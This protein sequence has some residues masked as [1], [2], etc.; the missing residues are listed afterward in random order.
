MEV[1]NI[2]EEKTEKKLFSSEDFKIEV[3]NL[4]KYFG[5]GQLKKLFSN[6]MKLDFH[7][8]KP[9]GPKTNY[10]YICF[11]N[12]EDKQKALMVIEGFEF[13]GNKLR[14]K[15]IKGVT[16][17]YRKK[18]Q[19]SKET[20][21]DTRPVAEQLQ[22][23]VCPLAGLPYEQQLGRKASEVG[24]LVRR[25]GSE[26]SRVHPCLKQWVGQQTRDQDTL[27]PVSSVLRSPLLQGYRNKCEFSVGRGSDGQVCVG[28][29]LASYKAGSVEIVSLAGLETPTTTLPHISAQMLAAV[30][31]FEQLVRASSLPPY[32][33]LDRSGNWRSLMLRSSRTGQLMAVICLD[34]GGVA[35]AQLSKVREDL[36]T[37]HRDVDKEEAGRVSSLYLHLSPARKEPGHVEPAPELL[38]GEAAIQETLLGR[39]FNISPQA[40]FQVNSGGAEL[41]YKTVGDIAGLTDK[42]SLVDVCCGTGTIGLCLADR[43]KNVVGVEMVSEAVRDAQKNAESNGVTN[44]SF[45]CG[46]AEDILPNILRD[47]DNK[48]IVAIVDPP[49]AGLHPRALAAIRNTLA[50]QTLVYVACDAKNAMKNFVDLSRPASKTAKGDPFLPVKIIPVD[51]FPHSKGFELVIL[52]ERVAWGSILNSEIAKRIRDVETESLE[53]MVELADRVKQERERQQDQ[54]GVKREKDSQDFDSGDSS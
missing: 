24:L 2:K 12:D 11:K 49:R 38:W 50:I 53:E 47:V 5:M 51:L 52:F 35:P 45:Y 40:F 22:G 26:I 8:L 42:T 37:A 3:Q 19:E 27:A 32:C 29:R 16:D 25:L 34:P 15:S 44:C 28:F 31:R 10:M 23:A 54:P 41:L 46:K 7:K 4:P 21:V 33:S 36:I 9:C 20:V 17:P 30:S 14:A 43:V 6:K 39:T 1:E 48:S 13:K 18:Q